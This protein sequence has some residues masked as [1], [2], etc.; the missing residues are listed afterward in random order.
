R[1]AGEPSRLFGLGQGFVHEALVVGCVERATD[2]S[3]GCE[4]GQA[5]YLALKLFLGAARVR[6]DL[7]VGLDEQAVALLASLKLGRR[8][9]L[10]ALLVGL[11]QHLAGLGLR[12]GDYL[13]GALGSLDIRLL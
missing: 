2:D 3:A 5:C 1:S 12:L 11:R 7:L 6:L 4:K 8:D 13:L 10:L 9:G